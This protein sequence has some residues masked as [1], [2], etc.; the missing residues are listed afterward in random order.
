MPDYFLDTSALAKHYH[1][2]VGT[3]VIEEV[4][5]STGSFF[6]VSRLTTIELH[7]VFARRVRTQEITHDAFELLRQRFFADIVEGKLTVVRVTDE[8]YRIAQ[9]LLRKH[10]TE[11][12]LR[13]LD[14]LQL[15]VAVDL[16]DLGLLGRF[17]CA[18]IQLGKVAAL[19]ELSVVN[20]EA[21]AEE[22]TTAT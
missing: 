14:A 12:S 6:F 17:V 16:R 10:A 7:S 20:P 9:G 2:E 4:L 22:Q 8:H 15:A 19:E 3:D 5:Q 1:Q 18:D 13:T 11:S 21:P